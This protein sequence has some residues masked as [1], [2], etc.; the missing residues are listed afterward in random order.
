MIFTKSSVNIKTEQMKI[1]YYYIVANFHHLY[2]CYFCSPALGKQLC[3]S[4]VFP[5]TLSS[6]QG[7]HM[8]DTTWKTD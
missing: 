4:G 7:L 3:C 5:P 1:T 2:S 8:L 6:P